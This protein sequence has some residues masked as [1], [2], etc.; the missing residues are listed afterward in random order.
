MG[1]F[2]RVF[3][4]DAI[5]LASHAHVRRR[6]SC[7][8]RVQASGAC[9]PS[10]G[11]IIEKHTPGTHS[12]GRASELGAI[13]GALGPRVAQSFVALL[14]QVL[15]AVVAEHGLRGD[16]RRTGRQHAVRGGVTLAAHV[17]IALETP[18]A[19]VAEGALAAAVAGL[20]DRT[21]AV[22]VAHVAC[23]FRYAHPSVAVAVELLCDEDQT[24]ARGRASPKK[25][26]HAMF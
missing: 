16:D 14:A 7:T 19:A 4:D 25:L 13:R 20:D 12:T 15:V 8:P 10:L 24:F 1:M 18:R 6:M 21:F 5:V 22:E 2:D 17:D 9:P 26:P 3:V 11:Q 23:L